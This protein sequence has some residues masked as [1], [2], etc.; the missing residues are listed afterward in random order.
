MFGIW[1]NNIGCLYLIKNRTIKAKQQK[2][3][4]FLNTTLTV[5]QLYLLFLEY[6]KDN[7]GMQPKLSYKMYHKFFRENSEF[8]TQ[9]LK[10]NVC[11]YC[12]A[13][14]VKLS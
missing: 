1:Q 5:K 14:N 4:F 7:T 6:C 10:T 8:S 3:I 12:T 13:C 9:Q 2:E 11:D